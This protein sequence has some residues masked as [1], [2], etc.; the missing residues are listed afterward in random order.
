MA[1]ITTTPTG[2]IS[3]IFAEEII[4]PSD[5]LARLCTKPFLLVRNPGENKVLEFIGAVFIY[6]FGT[7]AMSGGGNI[8]ISYSGFS[9]LSARVSSVVLMS[10]DSDKVL[11]MQL[12][13]TENMVMPVNSGLFLQ[14]TDCDFIK[15]LSTS[16]AK[17]HIMYRIHGLA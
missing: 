11:Q 2:S 13:N 12:T 7:A 10:D 17:I 6:K 16:Y 14:M 4:V 3:S 8:Y 9:T 5:S 1:T 15:G